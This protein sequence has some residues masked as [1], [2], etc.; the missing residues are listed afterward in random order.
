LNG[1]VETEGCGSQE[2]QEGR[3]S[4]EEAEDDLAPPKE[5]ADSP[6]QGG[7][8]SSSAEAPREVIITQA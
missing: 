8:E 6:R 7:S 5:D 4:G 2:H 3:R 1:D